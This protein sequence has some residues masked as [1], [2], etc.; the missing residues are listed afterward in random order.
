MNECS[1][2]LFRERISLAWP[3]LT[4]HTSK[5]PPKTQKRVEIFGAEAQD[6]DLLFHVL[7]DPS[8]PPQ[9]PMRKGNHAGKA[10]VKSRQTLVQKPERGRTKKPLMK[11]SFKLF[12]TLPFTF[13]IEKVFSFV[14]R[15]Y[16]KP[17]AAG[18]TH[19]WSESPSSSLLGF[20]AQA[21]SRASAPIHPPL[22]PEP[23]CLKVS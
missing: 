15:S 20:L 4:F 18:V 10:A 16:C 22:L 8:V 9:I 23:H 1:L 2:K 21:S 19:R 13:V 5:M 12:C 14:H 11:Y 6:C 7:I 3:H 17:I